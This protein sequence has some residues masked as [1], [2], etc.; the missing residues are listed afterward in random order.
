MEADL[1]TRDSVWEIE[2]NSIEVALRQT[3]VRSQLRCIDIVEHLRPSL[4]EH[5]K[6][7]RRHTLGLHS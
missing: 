6:A 5:L 7:P 2:H 3:S 1:A 4:E